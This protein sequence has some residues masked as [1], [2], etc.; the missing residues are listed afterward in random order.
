MRE[1]NFI[2]ATNDGL[3]TN[4]TFRAYTLN[5]AFKQA[6][7]FAKKHNLQLLNL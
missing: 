1:F 5:D 2:Y 6:N 7:L 4:K 3:R